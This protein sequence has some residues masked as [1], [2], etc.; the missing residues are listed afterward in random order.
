MDRHWLH[1]VAFTL[2]LVALVT[3]A[4]GTEWAFAATAMLTCGL[5]FG[6][7]YLLFATGAHFGMVMSNALA[8]YVRTRDILAPRPRQD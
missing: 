3:L 7:F 6:F 8:V 5:G 4:M 2:G 1:T